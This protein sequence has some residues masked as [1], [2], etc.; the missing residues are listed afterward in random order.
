MGI[1][2]FSGST[3]ETLVEMQEKDINPFLAGKV[4]HGTF[5]TMT[6]R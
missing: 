6:S 3:S 4:I 1:L 5:L 2:L